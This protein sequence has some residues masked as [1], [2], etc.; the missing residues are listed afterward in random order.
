MQNKGIVPQY[1]VENSYEPII[2]RDLY[3]R[4]QEE[5][6]R[7]ANSI[8]EPVGKRGFTAA[9]MPYAALFTAPSAERFIGGSHGITGENTPP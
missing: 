6:I 3:M 7:R 9:S 4:V 2:P 8:A 1:Y 5:M